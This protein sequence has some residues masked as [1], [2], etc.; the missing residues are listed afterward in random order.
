MPQMP[1]DDRASGMF[2]YNMRKIS[3]LTEEWFESSLF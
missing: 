3:N 2:L 1:H